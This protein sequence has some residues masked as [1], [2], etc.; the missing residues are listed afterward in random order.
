M[1]EHQY[2]AGVFHAIDSEGPIWPTKDL[3]QATAIVNGVGLELVEAVDAEN[4]VWLI[5]LLPACVAWLE[6]RGILELACEA[7]VVVVEEA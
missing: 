1:N 2:Q 3:T 5:T 7:G 6:D 4:G